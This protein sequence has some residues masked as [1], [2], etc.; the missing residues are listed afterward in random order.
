MVS[1]LYHAATGISVKTWLTHRK[2]CLENNEKTYLIEVRIEQH[3]NTSGNE[4]QLQTVA[5]SGLL[6]E[7]FLVNAFTL[8]NT[9]VL[10][11]QTI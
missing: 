6:K 10:M 11:I 3:I 4:N 2:N 5:M 7:P 1:T 8:N 9:W